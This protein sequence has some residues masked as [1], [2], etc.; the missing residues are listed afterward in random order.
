M[1]EKLQA[2]DNPKTENFRFSSTPTCRNVNGTSAIDLCITSLSLY[3]Q[4][5]YFKVLPFVWY[6][7]HAPILVC[8]KTG[9]FANN[10]ES[11]SDIPYSMF[12]KYKWNEK[13]KIHF[14]TKI[15]MPEVQ[16]DLEQLINQNNGDVNEL[17]K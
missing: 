15:K 5:L 10:N 17:T 13:S 2:E 12:S 8:I 3:D 16:A 4:I 6:S 1:V 9:K 11:D 14:Q 7:D